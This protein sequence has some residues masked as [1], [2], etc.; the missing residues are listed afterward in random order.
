MRSWK[1]AGGDAVHAPEDGGDRSSVCVER[2]G[3][4]GEKTWIE[5][6]PREGK[7]GRGGPEGPTG[8]PRRGRF[9][10]HQEIKFPEAMQA[11][12]CERRYRAGYAESSRNTYRPRGPPER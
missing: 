4:P 10:D 6:G 7:K 8:K 12:D 3:I 1:K 9:C 2:R 5:G 11:R